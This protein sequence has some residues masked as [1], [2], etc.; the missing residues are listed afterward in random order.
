[1]GAMVSQ[2]PASRLFTQSFIHI[3]EDI[4]AGEFPA[5]MASNAENVSVWWRHHAYD[6][7]WTMI[8]NEYIMTPADGTDTILHNW[9]W[10]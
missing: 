4:K 9:A 5:Q 7:C 3:K 1:M 2:I 10:N 8:W 6:S